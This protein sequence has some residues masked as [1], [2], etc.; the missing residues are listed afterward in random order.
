MDDFLHSSAFNHE[1][2]EDTKRVFIL[3]GYLER[4]KLYGLWERLPAAKLNDCGWKPLP[5]GFLG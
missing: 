3:S 4:K 1:A 5:R 2:H